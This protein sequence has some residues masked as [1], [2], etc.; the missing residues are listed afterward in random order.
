MGCQEW[1]ILSAWRT[2][3]ISIDGKD[4]EWLGKMWQVENVYIGVANDDEYL[5]LCLSA[6]DKTAK[7]Q[8]LG[9][10]RQS[11]TLWFD[12]KGRKRRTLG[13]K[14]SNESPF[15]DE[16]LVNKIHFINTSAFLLIANEMINNMEIEILKDNYPFALLSESKGIDVAMGTSMNGRKL[17]FEFKIPLTKT[18]SH[19]SAIEAQPGDTISVGLEASKIDMDFVWK[20]VDSGDAHQPKRF[21]LEARRA[22]VEGLGEPIRYLE[23]WGYIQLSKPDSITKSAG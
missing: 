23:L 3:E 5:Y 8:L 15:M 22:H 7:A 2:G 11:F 1:K 20:Q 21:M 18:E 4:A 10:F 13:I 6:T 14:I 19:P 16:S 17:T 12:G 9:L